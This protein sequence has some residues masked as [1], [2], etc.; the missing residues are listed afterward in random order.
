MARSEDEA[1]LLGRLLGDP[2]FRARFRL[3]PAG[4]AREAGLDGLAA[5]LALADDPMQ[6]LEL[7]ESRSSVA[8]VMMAAALEGIGIFAGTSLLDPSDAVAATGSPKHSW[9]ASQFGQG[10]SGGTPSQDA[11]SLLDNR[12]V[13]LDASSI[14]DLHA[15]RVDPRVVTLLTEISERHRV[16]VSSMSS[17]HPRLTAGGSVSNHYYGRAFDI[18]VV[19]GRRVESG[20][21]AARALAEEL[22]RLDPSIRP[23][24]IGSP[25]ALRGAA[26]FTDGDHQDHL[27]VGFDDPIHSSWSAAPSAV[28]AADPA[29]PVENPDDFEG[30]RDDEDAGA[31]EADGSN[32]V[33]P[34]EEGSDEEGSDEEGSDDEG[35]D[36]GGSDEEGSDEEGSDEEGS[37]EEGDEGSEDGEGDDDERDENEPDE[38]EPDENE[39][40]E[41]GGES[42]DDEDPEGE[43]AAQASASSENGDDEGTSDGDSSDD[44]SDD[45]QDDGSDSSDEGSDSSDSSDD[46]SADGSD[47]PE[48]SDAVAAYPGDEASSAEV[49]A[50]MANAAKERG[51]PPELPL[52]TG[53]VES[54]MRNLDYG[55]ADSVGYFQ[56]RLGIWNH[57]A[58]RGYA[59]DPRLQ[60]KWFLDRAEAVKSQR[61]AQGL[62]VDTGHYGEWIADV[63]R[64]AEEYRGRYQLRLQE[65]RAL[66]AKAEP[67]QRGGAQVVELADTPSV[68]RAGPRALT[69]LAE[70]K[71]YLGTPYRWGGSSPQSGFDCSGLVQWAYAHAGIRI[72]RV[73]DAQIDAPGG[74]AVSRSKL[75]PGDLVFFRN[76]SGYVHHVGISLGGDKFLHSP[77]TG[78]VVKTSSLKE[79]YYA[80]EFAGGRRFVKAV[81]GEPPVKAA[82][83]AEAA[84]A[85]AES[86]VRPVASAPPPEAA[87]DPEAVRI[88]LAALDRDAAEI[89]NM[90]SALFKALELQERDFGN[91]VQFLR[92]IDPLRRPIS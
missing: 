26:Y 21:A 84:Q 12:G 56:M 58:F 64:P 40:D 91:D 65:A 32:E 68:P 46:D 62:Q 25:W 16:T 67:R 83:A 71:K 7:R 10:G 76:A 70:A 13:V 15:G 43:D 61:V 73:T 38:D 29:A 78:D 18:A 14:A 8:G 75:L 90:N 24:E 27:H 51:L 30:E 33:E 9:D 74:T 88:A 80:R 72:P 39:A 47:E 48:L 2:D 23:S 60:L 69:A 20:N 19:D 63:Q 11:L 44:G 53:L 4:M 36:D 59:D 37:D 92:A 35:S 55:D 86:P 31:D 77:H 82:P 49:T 41:G 52:M 89:G 28:A 3:D 57:G 79:S 34:D 1:R 50:W 6:T 66:L 54:G 87:A 17:D 45:E 81:A 22:G 85:P 5:E 42:E